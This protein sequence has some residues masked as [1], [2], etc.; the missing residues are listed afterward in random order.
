MSERTDQRTVTADQAGQ[1]VAAIVRELVPSLSWS[2][3]RD[4]V[5]SGQVR[6]DGQAVTD[7]AQRL[8]AGQQIEMAA[9][10]SHS[11]GEPCREPELLVHLDTDVAVVRKPAGLMTVPFERTDRD[12]LL[13]RARVAIRRLETSRG[14]PHNPS[15]RAVQRLDKDT[16]GLVVF[17]RT[18]SAQR[19]L[20][21]QF[22]EHTALRRYLAVVHGRA[23]S[24]VYDSILVPDRGDG[25]RGSVSPSP[26]GVRSARQAITHVAVQE[27][28]RGAT[29]VSCRLET[30]RTHQIRIHMAEAGHPLLGETV[31]VR[32]FAGP[33]LPAPR[34][35]LHATELGFVHPRSGKEVR[36]TEPPPE[37]FAEAVERLKL[38]T[39][40]VVEG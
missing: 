31:Y 36:F 13:S 25:L 18:I 17:A 4:L 28:L 24:A 39:T 7:P 40:A 34:L 21:Q 37:D 14:L 26:Q 27:R 6:V 3:A 30:G 29:L 35:M 12:T 16:S 33:W 5:R 1:T 20:Q 11:R 15:L 32:D 10:G 22:T 19:D 38:S 2:K 8:R 23:R 9:G